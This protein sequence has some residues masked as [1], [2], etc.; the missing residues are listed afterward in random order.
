MSKNKK[1]LSA[2]DMSRISGLDLS[3]VQDCVKYG[4]ISR[5]EFTEREVPYGGKT[6]EEE[7]EK[8]LKIVKAKREQKPWTLDYRTQS[9]EEVFRQFLKAPRGMHRLLDGRTLQGLKN[10]KNELPYGY[11]GDVKEAMIKDGESPE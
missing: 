8:H 3:Y 1:E 10:L 9:A 2:E 5:H 4:V 7:M 6:K 11:V